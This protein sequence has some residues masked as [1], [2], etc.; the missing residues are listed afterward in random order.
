MSLLSFTELHQIVEQGYLHNLGSITQI[1]ATSIDVRL[2][3]EFLVEHNSPTRAAV[4]L[5]VVDLAAR[6][7]VTYD[8]VA[9]DYLLLPGE[10]VLAHTM[11]MFNLPDDISAEF[12]LKSSMARN[13][14]EHLNACWADAGFNNSSL[15]LELKN[16]L[17]HHALLLKPGMLVG[18]LKFFRHQP[19]P[20]HASYRARGR[21]NCDPSV[22]QIK[23]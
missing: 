21:Y 11:E 1:N 14:L 7:S 6:E 16:M 18:Q 20:E 15:T 13:G 9:G 3:S 5:P 4:G 10:F 23:K 2:G 19:V 17:R 22:Q 8:R 12:C